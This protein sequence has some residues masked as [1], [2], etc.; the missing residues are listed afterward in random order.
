MNG[1]SEAKLVVK[2]FRCFLRVMLMPG[3]SLWK[4]LMI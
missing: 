4:A 3:L 2:D 1:W